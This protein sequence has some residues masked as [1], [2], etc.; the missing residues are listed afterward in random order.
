MSITA[1][2]YARPAPVLDL[3][4]HP[5]TQPD[6]RLV[7]RREN[8]WRPLRLGIAEYERPFGSCIA[9]DSLTVLDEAGHAAEVTSATP[10]LVAFAG[11]ASLV[12]ADEATLSVA[13]PA[14]WSV[15]LGLVG[16]P[17]V[18]SR[19]GEAATG[20]PGKRVEWCLEGDRASQELAPDGCTVTLVAGPEE[21]ARLLIRVAGCGVT[22]EPIAAPPHAV[23]AAA[24]AKS[25]DA[26]F[27]RRPPVRADLVAAADLA[28]WVLAANRIR[29]GPHGASIVAPSKL[30]YVAAWQWDAYFIAAG[31]RHG[32]PEEAWK[33]L[34]FFLERALPDGQL[35]DVVSDRGAIY[36]VGDLPP[37]EIGDAPLEVPITKPPLAAWAV[38]L[39]HESLGEPE[40]L[41]WALPRL[42][43]LQ[44]WWETRSDLNCDGLSEYLHRFSS[45]LDDSPLFDRGVPAETPD[46]NAYLA[47]ADDRLGRVAACLGRPTAAAAFHARAEGRVARLV[48]RRWDARRGRF[49]AVGPGGEVDILT[50]FALM[51]LLTGRLGP[52]IVKPMIRTLTDP[53]RLWTP[54]PLA[55]VAADERTFDPERMWRGPVWLNV[56]R[57]IIEGLEAS[58]HPALAEELTERTLALVISSGGPYEHWNPFTGRRAASAT[59]AFSWSAALFIDLAVLASRTPHDRVRLSSA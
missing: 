6:S 31:L 36:R 53:S 25:W 8:R 34:S 17:L 39:V 43:A 35:P 33:Q 45:G 55:T 16:D 1:V 56:N 57:L 58:G 10:A 19:R 11:G 44:R 50:P 7:I 59:S 47:V 2:D 22:A 42:E 26:W 13:L 41:A 27:D 54:W 37:A 51:P 38:W 23:L 28:W 32:A 4:D 24:A 3:V 21:D 40:L 18:S 5:F 15:R 48:S 20:A 12:A 14:G 9:L 29:L 46:L 49:Q 30:G 52:S